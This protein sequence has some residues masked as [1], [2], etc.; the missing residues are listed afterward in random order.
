M[1]REFA[2]NAEKTQ[3]KSM[4]IIGAGMNHWY[5]SDMNY[6]G[7]INMLMLCGCIGKSGGGWSHYVGQEKLRP[8]TGWLPLAFG[9]EPLFE[10]RRPAPQEEAREHIAAVR[11]ARIVQAAFGGRRQELRDVAG[12]RAGIHGDVVV[13]A[14]V[15]RVGA[16]VR[17]NDVKGLAEGA[18]GGP[19]VE[20]RPEHA[21]ERVA[22]HELPRRPG[23][24]IGQHGQPLGLRDEGMEVAPVARRKLQRA[25]QMKADH[26]AERS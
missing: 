6:R 23:G 17:P 21:E 26:G 18:A 4:V 12:D 2:D 20:L 13:A 19:L 10:R 9:L 25:K 24:E 15:Q 5:H 1:A 8:Q 11:F 16:Q 3:G 7:I 22:A 14:R